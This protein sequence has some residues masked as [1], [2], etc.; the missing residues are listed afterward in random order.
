MAVYDRTTGSHYLNA[1]YYDPGTANFL[2]QD[3]YR[4]GL[5]DEKQWNLYGYCANDPV[6]YSDPTRHFAYVIPI[7]IV[8]VIGVSTSGTIISRNVYKPTIVYNPTR[9]PKRDKTVVKARRIEK[10]IKTKVKHYAKV[11]KRKVTY[12]KE[13]TKNKTTQNLE[14]HQRAEKRRA[15]EHGKDKKGKKKNGKKEVI[16]EDNSNSVLSLVFHK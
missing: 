3:T 6:N 7:I 8:V 13:H 1:R 11:A 4:D 9:I 15:M 10:K 2:S 12:Y 14:K 5:T 16:N